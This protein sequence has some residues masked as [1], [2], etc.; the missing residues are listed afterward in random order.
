M[1]S[2]LF[3]WQIK[4]LRIISCDYAFWKNAY[5]MWTHC[6]R[7]TF[8][9][10]WKLPGFYKVSTFES[11]SKTM[12]ASMSWNKWIFHGIEC[13]FFPFLRHSRRISHLSTLVSSF[14]S[15]HFQKIFHRNCLCGIRPDRVTIIAHYDGVKSTDT[16]W[17]FAIVIFIS[18]I[19]VFQQ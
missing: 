6:M 14:R 5:T 19:F 15:S 16:H 11:I 18:T 10:V 1:S 7:W 4:W 2:T 13:D 9:F 17:H 12:F 8:C 3:I